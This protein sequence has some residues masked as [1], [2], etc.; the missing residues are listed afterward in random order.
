V[1]AEWRHNLRRAKRTPAKI[2]SLLPGSEELCRGAKIDKK[3]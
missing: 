1:V 2:L 3:S